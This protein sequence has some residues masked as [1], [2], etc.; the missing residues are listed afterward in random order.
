[1]QSVDDKSIASTWLELLFF[2]STLALFTPYIKK[3]TTV[4][5]FCV[6]V[7]VLS[8]QITLVDPSVSTAGNFLII[9]CFLAIS[10][11]PTANTIVTIDDKASGIAATATAIA[12]IN[13]LNIRF[14]I[15]SP[16]I[17]P[18]ITWII[19]MAAANIIIIIPSF[20]PKSSNFSWS[21][22]CLLPALSNNV[23]TFPTSVFIPVSVTTKVPLP[24]T[25]VAPLKT[26]FLW[27]PIPTSSSILS[28][29]FKTAS[30]SPVSIPSTTFRLCA[31]I[32]LPSAGI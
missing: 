11:V 24:Y 23:A 8:V 22:V 4:I 28:L 2:S 15:F 3:S 26:I 21:G 29:C 1:M 13:E 9:A 6:N 12:N 25:T 30:A 19:K 5:L 31:S 32:N 10:F 17:Y 7:P 14:F 16:S 20:L 18:L 27:S